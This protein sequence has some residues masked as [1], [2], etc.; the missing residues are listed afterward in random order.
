MFK[1]SIPVTFACIVPVFIRHQ[2]P[3]IVKTSIKIS[4][5]QMYKIVS[6]DGS[7]HAA[8]K[9][10][11]MT[12]LLLQNGTLSI[13]ATMCAM[14]SAAQVTISSSVR[15]R[16]CGTPF[17]SLNKMCPFVFTILPVIFMSGYKMRV[18]PLLLLCVTINLLKPITT[19][20]SVVLIQ[21][22]TPATGND[23][24]VNVPSA[25]RYV[26]V[27]PVSL[28]CDSMAYFE[29]GTQSI[30]PLVQATSCIF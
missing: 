11:Y 15:Q 25:F 8:K 22:G 23:C 14:S 24:T 27:V 4:C 3:P 9:N 29:F 6:E 17:L 21:R 19:P 13:S 18:S 12:L 1:T 5:R 10:S 30:F 20:S 28:S 7:L 2:S 16:P 26:T